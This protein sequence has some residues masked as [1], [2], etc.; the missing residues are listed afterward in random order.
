M[1][2]YLAF[3]IVGNLAAAAH[4]GQLVVDSAHALLHRFGIF[5]EPLAHHATDFFG[6][7]VALGLQRF[8]L[9]DGAASLFVQLGKRGAVPR[10][11]AVAHGLGHRLL[12]FA[13]KLN[14]QH[15]ISFIA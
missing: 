8:L 5:L 14:V 9:L 10:S 1:G 6:S 3:C 12:V 2:I 7:S 4:L 13:N 11:I 15:G